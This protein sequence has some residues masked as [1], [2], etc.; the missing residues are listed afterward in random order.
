MSGGAVCPNCGTAANANGVCIKCLL[1]T[2][3]PGGGQSLAERI[4]QAALSLEPRERPAFAERAAEGNAA[5]HTEVQLLLEGYAEAGGD[6]AQA[7][8][9]GTARERWAA[10]RREEPGTVIDHFRLVRIIGEGGMGSVWEA[11]QT[12]P[13]KRRVAL[14]IIKL[15]MDTE[16]VVRRF[17]RERRTLALMTHPHIAQVFEAGA[18]P[19]GRPY[20]A[21]E[22][23]EGLAITA[24]CVAEGLGVRHRLALFLEV[25][26][27]VEHAHQKGIIHRDLKPSNILVSGGAVKVIDFGVAKATRDD[28][29]DGLL[30]RE[31][32]VLG[33]PAYMSPE[34][35]DSNGGDVDTR[36]DVYSLGAVLYELLSGALPFD[37]KRFASTHMREV[38]R[39][40]REEIPP[41]PST[42][43]GETSEAR[44]VHRVD[45]LGD[46]DWIILKALSKERERR[47]SSAAA[48]AEDVRCYLAEKMVSAVPPTLSYRFGKFVRRNKA[49]V[50]AVAAV[51]VSLAGGLIVS[52]LQVQRT[53]EALA[54]EAKARAAAT[55]TVADLYT[56]SG[57]TAAERGDASRAA[58]WFTH[59]AQIA[60]ADPDR[61]AVNRLR[62]AAWTQECQEPV[63]AFET[64]LPHIEE[65]TFHPGGKALLLTEING[66]RAQVWNL[67]TEEPWLPAAGAGGA[68]CDRNGERICLS[69][70]GKL[71]VVEY[72][73]GRVLAEREG[74]GT[75]EVAFDPSGEMIAAGANPPL[76]WHWRSGKTQ[77][78]PVLKGGI[79]RVRWSPDGRLVLWQT[80][81]EA[82]VSAA[83][84][85]E[86]LLTGAVPNISKCLTDFTADGA[87]FFH[88]DG[89]RTILRDARTGEVRREIPGGEFALAA[90]ADGTRLAR[91]AAP[92][93][94]ADGMEHRTPSHGPLVMMECG[95]FSPDES[96]LATAG[97][98]GS[99]RLWEAGEDRAIG[100]VGWHQHPVQCVAWSGDGA[101]LAS[102]QI[103]LVRVWRVKR[104]PLLRALPAGAPSLAAVSNDGALLAASGI[105]QST[106]TLRKTRVFN[107]A[108]GQPAGP[109]L[110]TDGIITDAAFAPDSSYLA[111]A[112][113]TTPDRLRHDWKS[114]G[115]GYLEL[116]DWKTGASAG[117]RVVLPSEPRGLAV[118]PS[119]D[120]VA[121]Y[122]GG[123]EGLEWERRTGAL[124]PLFSSGKVSV[125][126]HTLNNGRIAYARSGRTIVAWGE[127]DTFHVWD[128]KDAKALPARPPE[129][130]GIIYGLALHDGVAALA[131]AGP[132]EPLLSFTDL[133][134]GLEQSDPVKHSDWLYHAQFDEAGRLVLTTGRRPVVQVWDWR[135]RN[136]AG[137]ALQHAG[138]VMA[139]VFVPGTPWVITGAH[140]G[141]IRFWDRRCGMMI[142]PPIVRNGRVLQLKLTPDGRYLIAGGFLEDGELDVI[143]LRSALPAAGRDAGSTREVLRAE[144]IAAATMHENGG[145]VPL[146]GEGWLEK[147]K[148]LRALAKE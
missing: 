6:A 57:L 68:A 32:Q 20:F 129:E 75:A 55:F 136:P 70:R 65:M 101:L 84:H 143:D 112:V 116:R 74:D 132:A 30:T 76:L 39:I 111:L 50:A 86:T 135:N 100:P 80:M 114:G 137:P 36:T 62:A 19:A 103:G 107:V 25:C 98:D 17:E 29:G 78:G 66:G 94:Q 140:D 56:R 27:A 81:E 133:G 13:I 42:R 144:I 8:L 54:G 41:P 123:G 91:A 122:C 67:E 38:H 1:D 108:P 142:R 35:A 138:E 128:R 69:I 2:G 109:E 49:A 51:V 120:F 105:T 64:G 88:S 83:E 28:G 104:E 96:V 139:G 110:E 125:A 118:H 15:G 60:K 115:A 102:S 146:T 12:D 52:L 113:S 85:P 124:R 16:E 119:G 63:A 77:T 14:K 10:V 90:T 92:L 53:G 18:T 48:F 24:H 46:L 4:F 3:V 37:P 121:L 87:Q 45:L 61:A 93:W 141:L 95:R 26:G 73:S 131:P 127:L 33:T 34:Q 71:R 44:P 147:W 22:L 99:V 145:I 21:M 82:A 97:Y 58:L 89:Q 23:V 126:Q 59:A 40:L 79:R 130:G 134:T 72:P 117:P 31:A 43:I 148:L 47:Y 7:T 106:G 11:E 9:G 5:L